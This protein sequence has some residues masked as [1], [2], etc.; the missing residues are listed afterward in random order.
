MLSDDIYAFRNELRKHNTL[1]AYT[2]FVSEDLLYSLGTAVKQQLELKKAEGRIIRRVFSVFV[3]QVQNIIRYSDE[4]EWLAGAQTNRL[5][6]GV[7]V[8]GQE[9]KKFFVI[10][11]NSVPGTDADALRERLTSIA[12][13]D[14]EALRKHYRSKLREEPESTSEGASIGLLE[15]ARR[16]TAPLQFDFLDLDQNR[17][18]FVLKAFI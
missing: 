11:G 13:M 16:S 18:F 17:K 8:L 1:F 14:G 10:C 7:I 3:E 12:A 2:G 6:S 15:I 9:D 5:S 4:K